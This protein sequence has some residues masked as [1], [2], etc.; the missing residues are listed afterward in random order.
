MIDEHRERV[1]LFIERF[2]INFIYTIIVSNA[3][4][5]FFHRFI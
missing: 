3:L 5:V 4:F 2:Q 1:L